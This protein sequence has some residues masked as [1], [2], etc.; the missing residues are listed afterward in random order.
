[1]DDMNAIEKW[2][3]MELVELLLGSSTDRPK[4][5]LFYLILMPNVP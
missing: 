5:F 4:L 2:E 1:M 3:V